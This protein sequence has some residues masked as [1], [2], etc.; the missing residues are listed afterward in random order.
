MDR[1]QASQ[2]TTGLMLIA[3]GLM[4]LA[5]RLFILPAV[6]LHRLW[7]A[8]LIVF[9]L[10]RALAPARA[11]NRGGGAWLIFVGTMFLLHTYRV[12]RLD[13]SW[14]LFIVAAGVSILLGPHGLKPRSVVSDPGPA[15]GAPSGLA[16]ESPA[17]PQSET[18]GA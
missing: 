2:V 7:P 6:D 4:F 5:E 1:K 9:G 17:P 8:L 18:H 15:A 3:L 10:S 14:P 13:E 12:L 16:P 11:G